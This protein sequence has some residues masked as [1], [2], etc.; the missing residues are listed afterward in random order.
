MAQ[1]DIQ[2]VVS[3]TAVFDGTG[4]DISGITGD[5]TLH[6]RVKSLTAG[7][8]IAFVFADTVDNFTNSVVRA[9][10]NFK[11]LLASSYDAK[12]SWRKY[13]LKGLRFGTASAKL[14]LSLVEISAGTVEYEAWI[15]Y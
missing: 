15:E 3:K 6:L 8:N 12:V 4:V 13:E 1:T 5:V 10:A 14:R 9:A 7:A 11:G 2:A